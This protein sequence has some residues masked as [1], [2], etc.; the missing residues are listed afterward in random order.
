MK[1]NE[2]LLIRIPTE[3]KRRLQSL[4]QIQDKSVSMIVRES[5]RYTLDRYSTPPSNKN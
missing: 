2:L 3:D 5:Y 1:K 4:G